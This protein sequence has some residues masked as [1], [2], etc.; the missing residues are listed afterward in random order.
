VVDALKYVFAGHAPQKPGLAPP[1][2]WRAPDVQ[3]IVAHPMHWVWPA[4]FW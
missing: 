4:E 2:S 3:G 1:Q